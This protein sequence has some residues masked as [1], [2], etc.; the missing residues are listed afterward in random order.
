MP[1]DLGGLRV[2]LTNHRR[3]AELESALVRRGATIVHAP[4]LS[5]VPHADDADLTAR[6]Q[7][8]IADPP[9]VL[10]VTTGVGLRG[11]IEAADAAGLAPQL[12]AALADTRIIARGPKAKGALH[13]AG[14]AAEWTA[15]SETAA[16]V[17]EHLLRSGVDGLHVAVQH[18]GSGDDGLDT[19]FTDAGARVTPVIV[20]RV[21]P[22]PDPEAV[23]RGIDLVADRQV[24]AVVFSSAPMAAE[25]LAR[26]DDRG[27][28]AQVVSACSPQGG[29]LA[30]TVGPVTAGPLRHAGI[31]PLVPDRYR[32]GALIRELVAALSPRAVARVDTPAGTLVVRDRAAQL[33]GKPLPV[34]P[35]GL[36]VLRVLATAEG[37]VVTRDAILAELP[38]GSTNPHTA[39]MAVARLR[40]TPGMRGLVQTVTKRGYRLDVLEG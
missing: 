40:E 10:V 38:S 20:Y 32:L 22:S 3:A 18:H 1:E 15:E 19:L 7:E 33:A 4:V 28:L 30:A 5:I 9:D 31:E 12:L 26:A 13:Q 17:G 2:L 8:L 6:T 14:L 25:F 27:R 36:A 29:V 24:D 37:S 23:T 11:W 16:E 34:T 39:E 35:V 21:G